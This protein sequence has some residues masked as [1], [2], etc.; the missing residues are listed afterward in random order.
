MKTFFKK[1]KIKLK[2]KAWKKRVLECFERDN[3][4]DQY[5]GK[6]CCSPHCHHRVFVSQGGDDRLENLATC[7]WE[8]HANHGD[9][10]DKPLFFEG[11]DS[12][13]QGLKEYFNGL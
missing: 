1:I 4:I 5:T 8:T 12:V 2:G 9:L 3:Y 7:E 6:K 13:I 11:D 10:K